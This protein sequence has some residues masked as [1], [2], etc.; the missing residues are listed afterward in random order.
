MNTTT[1]I[2]L[3]AVVQTRPPL[4]DAHRAK[5]SRVMRETFARIRIEDP[6][7]ARRMIRGMN[8]VVA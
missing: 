2:S 1:A 7:K 5:L 6:E 3:P 8:G 4:T